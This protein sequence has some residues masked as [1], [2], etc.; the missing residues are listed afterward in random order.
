MNSLEIWKNQFLK[1]LSKKITFQLYPL[2]ILMIRAK[3]GKTNII[4]H[5]TKFEVERHNGS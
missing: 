4:D 2:I 3:H 1:R 5:H